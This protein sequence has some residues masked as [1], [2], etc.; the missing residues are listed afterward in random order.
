MANPLDWL[1]GEFERTDNILGSGLA[2]L[3]RGGARGGGSLLRGG[4]R[5]YDAAKV[6]LTGSP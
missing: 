4:A 5:D 1:A 2:M 6:L 3:V